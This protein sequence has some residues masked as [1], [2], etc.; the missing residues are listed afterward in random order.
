[1]QLLFWRNWAL[2]A[3]EPQRE[4]IPPPATNTERN[5]DR[6]LLTEI[7]RALRLL[8]TI[9]THYG[10]HKRSATCATFAEMCSAAAAV[11]EGRLQV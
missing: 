1:M 4:F 3:T 2:M 11:I 5:A 7:R 8:S 9:L 6:W 10:Q